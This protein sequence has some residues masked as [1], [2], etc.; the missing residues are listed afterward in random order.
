LE[1]KNDMKRRGARSPDLAE[2]I[3]M[4]CAGLVAIL[5]EQ[6]LPPNIYWIE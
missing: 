6:L 1:S 3:I 4:A 5:E 2:A